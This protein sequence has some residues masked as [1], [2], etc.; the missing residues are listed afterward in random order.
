MPSIKI[1]VG[2]VI[3]IDFNEYFL[4]NVRKIL[5]ILRSAIQPNNESTLLTES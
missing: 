4:N 2:Q 5:A 3:E 1:L